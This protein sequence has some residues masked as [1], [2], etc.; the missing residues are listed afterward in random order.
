VLKVAAGAYF[1]TVIQLCPI[2]ALRRLQYEGS[3]Q[4]HD[5]FDLSTMVSHFK[6]PQV[7]A[8]SF[9]PS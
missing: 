7:A 4:F 8:V 9:S 5:L 3:E 2:S 6:S 1:T